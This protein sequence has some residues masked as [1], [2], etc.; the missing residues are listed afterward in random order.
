MAKSKPSK[1][2]IRPLFSKAS[3]N[4]MF[5][6]WSDSMQE[7]GRKLADLPVYEDA[8]P[9]EAFGFFCALDGLRGNEPALRALFVAADEL[10]VRPTYEEV[11]QIIEQMRAMDKVVVQVVYDFNTQRKSVP[12]KTPD[13]NGP[14]ASGMMRKAR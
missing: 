10:M 12:V 1:T 14:T 5:D 11:F 7:T 2:I 6:T 8:T 13:F 4:A 9:F 3:L